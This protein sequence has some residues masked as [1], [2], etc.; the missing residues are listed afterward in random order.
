MKNI[1]KGIGLIAVVLI[2][3]ACAPEPVFRL[4]ADHQDVMNYQGMEYLNS[5]KEESAVI[6]AYYRHIG[7]V[8]VMDA[9][10]VNYSGEIL[11]VD[12]S[13]V[14][15]SAIRSYFDGSYDPVAEGVAK[16]PEIM[17]LDLDLMASRARAAERTSRT[18]DAIS[19]TMTLASDLSASRNESAEQ[20]NLRQNRRTR[21]AVERAERRE[22]FYRTASDL[23]SR[24][25]Y[26]ESETLRRTDLY[27]DESIAGEIMLPVI[28]DANVIEIAVQV[29]NEVHTFKYL[30][31]TYRP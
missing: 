25:S 18:M 5:E 19:G 16:D 2:A 12:A 24:R 17:L 23:N 7:D 11:T 9:E 21:Q 14:T 10:I 13:N 29:G 8:I 20:L 22:N 15:F 30:Q 28:K 31:Q 27:P 6:L 3:A 4:T 26:W 1:K